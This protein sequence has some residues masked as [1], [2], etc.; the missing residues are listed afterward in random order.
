MRS[1]DNEVKVS[2][3]GEIRTITMRHP[4]APGEDITIEG[5]PWLVVSVSYEIPYRVPS[6]EFMVKEE[7]LQDA[8]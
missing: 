8:G 5:E 4:P 7:P 1:Q 2:R 6:M 3:K